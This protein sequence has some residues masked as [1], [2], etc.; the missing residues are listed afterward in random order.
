MI[1]NHLFNDFINN[2]FILFIIF[3]LLCIYLNYKE[4]V[5]ILCEEKKTKLF[6]Y[7]YHF[8]I[9]KYLVADQNEIGSVLFNTVNRKWNEILIPTGYIN[10]KKGFDSILY[11]ISDGTIKGLQYK[12]KKIDMSILNEKEFHSMVNHTFNNISHCDNLIIDT[13]SSNV[14]ILHEKININDYPYYKKLRSLI[15]EKKIIIYDSEHW[16]N[17]QND[18]MIASSIK[19]NNKAIE[20]LIIKKNPDAENIIL[21]INEVGDDPRFNELGNLPKGKLMQKRSFNIPLLDRKY[22][23]LHLR[24][25][26][27]MNETVAN[28]ILKVKR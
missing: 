24:G 4:P 5:F 3:I 2:R 17:D 25:L 18:L 15:E 28:E 14:S 13:N 10:I 9:S 11:N 8:G 26:Q 7:T 12:F 1:I 20:D 19:E 23:N 27:I 6:W 21:K 22:I 16:L